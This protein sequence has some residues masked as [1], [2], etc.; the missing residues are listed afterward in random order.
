MVIKRAPAARLGASAF[1]VQDRAWR[2]FADWQL[3]VL[4]IHGD[5]D[6]LVPVEGSRRFI[7]TVPANDKTYEEFAG[8]YHELLHDTDR[9]RARDVILSWVQARIE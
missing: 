6:R 1:K 4:V 5:A 7:E 8:G 2:D 9:D 3:P